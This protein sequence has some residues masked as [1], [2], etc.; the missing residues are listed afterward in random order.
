VR[1]ITPE[2]GYYFLLANLQRQSYKEAREIEKLNLTARERDKRLREF[3]NN[4][5]FRL[6][7]TIGEANGKLIRFSKH[8]NGYLVEWKLGDQI[9]KSTI[10][11]NMRILNAGFCLSGED[12]KHSLSSL[13]NLAQLFQ[14]EAPLYLTRE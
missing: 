12:K 4:F 7:H 10:N 11:D 2:L 9:I 6:E 13:I 3:Q 1:G 8:G 5:S 14:E